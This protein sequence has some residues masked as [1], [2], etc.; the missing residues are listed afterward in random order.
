MS[1]KASKKTKPKLLSKTLVTKIKIPVYVDHLGPA[2]LEEFAKLFVHVEHSK[3]M[4]PSMRVQLLW[5][6]NLLR[7]GEHQHKQRNLVIIA[8]KN[9]SKLEYLINL[10][11][12]I[13]VVTCSMSM[14]TVQ[15][16]NSEVIY[17]FLKKIL[18]FHQ[19]TISELLLHLSSTN[20][21]LLQFINYHGPINQL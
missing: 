6:G 7:S 20:S 14:P 17:S 10:P 8:N 18:H 5:H 15:N 9:F 16:K 2:L 12:D 21:L 19:N 13:P 11:L 1:T 3:G 4:P